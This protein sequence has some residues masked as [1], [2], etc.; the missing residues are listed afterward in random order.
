MRAENIV[1]ELAAAGL[2]RARAG[3]P[4]SKHTSWRV[5]GPADYFGVAET[6]E[7][8]RRAIAVAHSHGL[9]FL[10]LGGGSNILVADSGIAGLV[11]LNRIRSLNLEGDVNPSRL[12]AGAGVFFARAA[13]F[14]A[15]RGYSG[16]EWGIAIPGTVGASVV[17]NAG[18]HDGDVSRSLLETEALVDGKIVRLARKELQFRYR[19]SSLKQAQAPIQETPVVITRCWFR[20]DRGQASESMD[21]ITD[22]MEKR[23][24]TQPIAEPSGGSTFKNPTGSSAGALIEQAGLKGNRI[25]GAEF[26]SKHANFIVNR[27]TATASDIVELMALA[28]TKVRA[29]FGLELEPEVQLIGRWDPTEILWLVQRV[30]V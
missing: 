10:V 30:G 15:K 21:L 7:S 8:L 28:Q 13:L 4:M 9:G 1:D 25:G 6:A 23:R 16:L 2:S 22:L 27:G 12:E 17:N 29:R 24:R 18:A 26:S 20:V 14:S 3:E 11:I 19:E 5:G